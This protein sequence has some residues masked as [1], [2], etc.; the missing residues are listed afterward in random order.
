MKLKQTVLMISLIGL[1]TGGFAGNMGDRVAEI[2]YHPM[3]SL[4]G[5]VGSLSPRNQNARFFGSDEDVFNYDTHEN[6]QTIG[7]GGVF[8]GVEHTLF[9]PNLLLQWGVEYDYFGR[10]TLGG[11]NSIGIEPATS[12]FYTFQYNTQSQQ[13]L[14]VA[15]LLTPVS[16]PSVSTHTFY[17]YA[18]VGLGGA[19]NHATSFSTYTSEARSANAAPI[20][21]DSNQTNFSYNLGLGV[22]TNVSQNLRFG[23]GYRFSD[24]GKTALAQGHI[25]MGNYDPPI[26]VPFALSVPHVY[27]NQFA[28]SLS[29]VV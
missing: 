20:Y 16:V 12:T 2:G 19:F 10:G 14:G 24:F 26:G 17:P 22:D 13:V 6:A 18:S 11:N 25:M 28:V 23:L 7:F 8:L 3:I 27:A 1:T 15:K 5:G 9:Q 29:Y 4:L 21:G